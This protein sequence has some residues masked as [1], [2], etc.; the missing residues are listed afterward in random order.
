MN[1]RVMAYIGLGSNLDDPAAQIA[2]A[3]DALKTLPDTLAR[4]VSG[5]YRNPPMGPQDQPD[6]VNAVLAIET[7]LSPRALLDA[8]QKIEQTQGR[9]RSLHLWG[10]RIIDLDLLVYGDALLSED[11]LKVP[12]PGI[13]ERAFVLVPLAEIAPQLKIPTL[14][15]LPALLAAVD[16]A[17][18]ILM[19]VPICSMPRTSLTR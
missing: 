10:P 8:M 6:F 4:A 9:E 19:P 11:R 16:C 5:F 17:N 1:R 2:N 15:P 12:H 7:G 14:G 3:I 18:V 13:A